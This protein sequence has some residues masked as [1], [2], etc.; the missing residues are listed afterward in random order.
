[1]GTFSP[2]FDVLIGMDIISK[3][4]FSISNYG[5][6]TVFSFRSPSMGTTDYAEQIRLLEQNH[7]NKLSRNAP[8]P[9]GSGRKYKNCCGKNK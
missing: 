3:G 4:D 6:H 2:G 8:C 7:V 5:G 1:M 9:C